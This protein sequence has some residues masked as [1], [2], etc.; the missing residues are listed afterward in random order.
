MWLTSHHSGQNLL[1]THL[2]APREFMI[3]MNIWTTL[4]KRID[5]AKPHSI[6]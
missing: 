2:A 3:T 5:H 4:Y 6:C 1:W